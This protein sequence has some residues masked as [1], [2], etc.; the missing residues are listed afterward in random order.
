MGAI[1][2]WSAHKKAP[3]KHILAS[4]EKC[5]SIVTF[6]WPRKGVILYGSIN[7]KKYKNQMMKK[8]NK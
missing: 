8:T 7:W 6:S 1:T 5:E 2:N 4:T 3:T